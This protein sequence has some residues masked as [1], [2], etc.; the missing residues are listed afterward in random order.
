MIKIISLL[1][2]G[3]FGSVYGISF[4]FRSCATSTNQYAESGDVFTL[5]YYDGSKQ[6]TCDV[7]GENGS[8]ETVYKCSDRPKGDDLTAT[9]CVGNPAEPDRYGL[10]ISNPYNENEQED[11]ICVSEVIANGKSYPITSGEAWVGDGPGSSFQNYIFYQTGKPGSDE[12]NALCTTDSEDACTP[13][14][15]EKVAG[16]PACFTGCEFDFNKY[17]DR[18]TAIC[19]ED[20]N[21]PAGAQGIYNPMN[22]NGYYDEDNYLLLNK[23]ESLENMVFYGF[24]LLVS[25]MIVMMVV[26]ACSFKNRGQKT[27]V[28]SM[29]SEIETLSK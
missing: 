7:T 17:V 24:A 18:C 10:Q 19:P 14:T 1:T 27:V 4:G 21:P 9:E 26:M 20:D 3:F 13:V 5:T 16:I 12:L 22:G 15:G 11:D 25:V 28:Y 29:D 8:G 2:I 6:F 23:I